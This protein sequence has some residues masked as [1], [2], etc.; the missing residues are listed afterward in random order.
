[1]TMKANAMKELGGYAAA[2]RVRA[3]LEPRPSL[4]LPQALLLLLRSP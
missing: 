4:G 2:F 3:P 1:M